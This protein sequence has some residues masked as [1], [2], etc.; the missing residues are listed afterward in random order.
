MAANRS[1]PYL[2]MIGPIVILFAA[3]AVVTF[4]SSGKTSLQEVSEGLTCQCGCGLTVANCNHPQCGFSVP[5]RQQI[6]TMI[7]QGMGREQI[8]GFFRAKY[9]EKILSAP[10][11]EGFNLLAWIIPFAAVFA[12]CFIIVGAISRWRATPVIQAEALP[13]GPISYDPELKHRLE[14]EIREQR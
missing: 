6:E 1:M 14:Q 9:G 4:A 8:I 3:V 12:G 13:N 5:V 7:A 11:T 2:L 10:T